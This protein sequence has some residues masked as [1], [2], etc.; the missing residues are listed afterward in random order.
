MDEQTGR[1]ADWTLCYSEPLSHEVSTSSV[2]AN[3]SLW[4]LGVDCVYGSG[5][6]DAFIIREDRWLLRL[7]CVA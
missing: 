3:V 6:T 4:P 7:A 1:I 5:T 2:R